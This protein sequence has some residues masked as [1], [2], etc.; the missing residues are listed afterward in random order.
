MAEIDLPTDPSTAANRE[1][2]LN[3]VARMADDSGDFL[4]LGNRHWAL[5]VDESPTLIVS[6]ETL[7]EARARPGQMPLAHTI[8]AKHGWSHLCI[9]ADGATWWRDPAVWRYFDRLVDDAFFED[10][11]RV[12]FTGAG[13]GAYAACAYSVV[14]PGATVLAFAPAATLDPAEAGW[15]R[16]HLAARRMDFRSRYGYAPEMLD[17][18]EHAFLVLDP[19]E[20][21]DAM[22]AALFRAPWVT[23]LHM[24]HS[25]PNPAQVL[26][27]M[28]ELA[29]LIEAAAKG[30]LT[31]GLFARAW[32]KRRQF[33]PYLRHLIAITDAAGQLRRSEAICRNVLGRQKAPRIKRRLQQLQSSLGTAQPPAAVDEAD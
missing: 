9:I 2:W 22:H 30:E 28:G 5:F 27:D 21:L 10:F 20:T 8:A 29:P 7:A 33:A 1:G 26:S 25:G 15:D 32:R 17:G 12:L 13:M 24:R 23:R 14:S 16:R 11:D 31:P 6:F 4:T 3:A 18:A 19:C